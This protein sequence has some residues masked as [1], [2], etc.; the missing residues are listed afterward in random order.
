MT[1]SAVTLNS[2][3]CTGQVSSAPAAGTAKS[4][5]VPQQ[6]QAAADSFSA[7]APSSE[8]VSQ[9][10]ITKM[11]G[12][13]GTASQAEAAP[14]NSPETAAGSEAPKAEGTVSAKCGECD[15]P[16]ISE[17]AGR[18]D[19]MADKREAACARGEK[20]AAKWL[21]EADFLESKKAMYD[22]AKAIY[23]QYSARAE[24]LWQ[25]GGDH[26]KRGDSMLWNPYAYYM[27]L[28]LKNLGEYELKMS[29]YYQDAAAQQAQTMETCKGDPK[30]DAAKAASLRKK[31]Q[32]NIELARQQRQIALQERTDA[33]RLRWQEQV[34]SGDAD[35]LE[36][37]ADAHQASSE[38][39]IRES[40]GLEYQIAH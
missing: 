36:A 15:P 26:V 13:A 19:Q 2:M 37:S 24:Q 10:D 23:E 11:R 28:S 25:Q 40:A 6:P 30:A 17:E 27:G 29:A 3:N 34:N 22:R 20:A 12:Q 4:A 9:A 32:E 1:I 39:L 8:E 7:A 16:S 31:A 14:Q 35:A 33:A 18:L 21:K 5:E 38:S